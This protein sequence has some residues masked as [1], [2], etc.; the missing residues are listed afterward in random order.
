M[1]PSATSVCGL[2]LLV[3]AALSYLQLL[4][5]A[6]LS[7]LQLLVYAALSYLRQTTRHLGRTGVLSAI[8]VCGLKLLDAALN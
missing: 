3:Y 7:Y 1:R 8:S 5:Y 6:A 4:V 2:K